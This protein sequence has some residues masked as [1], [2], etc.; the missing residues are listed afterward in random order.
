MKMIIIICSCLLLLG[1]QDNNNNGL[2]DKEIKLKYEEM[3]DKLIEYG[4]LVYENEQWLNKNSKIVRTYMTLRDLS[5]NNQYDI[6]MF[7]NPK[8]GKKC[9][10]DNTKIE[11]IISNVDDLENIEYKFNPILVCDVENSSSGNLASGLDDMNEVVAGSNNLYNVLISYMVSIYY[12]D[13]YMNGGLKPNIYKISLR[14]F[15]KMGYDISKFYD[16][17]GKKCDLD[18]SY[19]IFEIYGTTKD[20]KTDYAFGGNLDC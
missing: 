6:S 11:F 9:N 7:V 13:E 1:C 17:T 8:T 19:G 5:L 18:N 3:K 12:K 16:E 15:E 10:L 2:T 20:G 4:K 14:E